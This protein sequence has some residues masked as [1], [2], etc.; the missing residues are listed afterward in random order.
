M[1]IR[2]G[3]VSNSSSSSFIIAVD[4]PKKCECCGKLSSPISELD[5][6]YDEDYGNTIINKDQH[7]LEMLVSNRVY[8]DNY[9]EVVNRVTNAL[10]NGKEVLEIKISHHD[11]EA[12]DIIHSDEVEIIF[13]DSEFD[14]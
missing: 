10:N 5:I 9:E 4:K 11:Q 13:D 1:K 12:Y 7:V 3:F 14:W 8:I 2:N 6:S